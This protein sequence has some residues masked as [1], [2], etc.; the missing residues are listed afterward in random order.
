[1]RRRPPEGLEV[2]VNS[3]RRR[4]IESS[5]VERVAMTYLH[6]AIADET[7]IVCQDEWALV[8]DRRKPELPAVNILETLLHAFSLLLQGGRAWDYTT[9]MRRPEDAKTWG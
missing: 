6:V 4:V 3:R 9:M 1:M 7:H 5:S 2:S 8:L